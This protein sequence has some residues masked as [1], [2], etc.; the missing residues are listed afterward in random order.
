MDNKPIDWYST[1]FITQSLRTYLKKKRYLLTESEEER[2]AGVD[3]IIVA[4]K[5]LSKEIIEIRGTINQAAPA[6]T[7]VNNTNEERGFINTLHFLFNVTL[8]PISFFTPGNEYEDRSLCLPGLDHHRETLEKLEDYFTT[9]SLHLKVYLVNQNG[10]VD[11][12]QL[13]PAKRIRA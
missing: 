7:E 13:N 11:I 9:H 5:R 12:F 10:S 8:S 2:P 1:Q 4:A 3:H 6:E